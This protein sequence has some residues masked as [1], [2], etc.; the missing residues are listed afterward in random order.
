MPELMGTNAP[1]I[2]VTTRSFLPTVDDPP[3]LQ[4]TFLEYTMHAIESFEENNGRILR[5]MKSYQSLCKQYNDA[6]QKV[7]ICEG[8]PDEC[9][10]VTIFAMNAI[11]NPKRSRRARTDSTE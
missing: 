3:I 9:L 6:K 11:I 2:R 4:R 8:E 10:K 7:L 5:R 1:P